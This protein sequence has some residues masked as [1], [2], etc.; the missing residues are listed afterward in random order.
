MLLHTSGDVFAAGNPGGVSAADQ[1]PNHATPDVR[2]TRRA[3]WWWAGTMAALAIAVTAAFLRYYEP[4]VGFTY[5]LDFGQMAGLREM[6]ELEATP[7]YVHVGLPGYDGQFYAQLA[8]RPA[9][10][11]PALLKAIDNPPYRARRMMMGWT[12]WLA[13]GGRPF[14]VLNAFAL[15]NL[16]AWL[17]LGALLLRWFPPAGLHDF[18]RWAGVMLSAGMLASLRHALTDGPALLALAGAVALVESRQRWPAIGAIAAAG[19]TRETSLLGAAVFAPTNWRARREW[20]RALGAVALVVL[21][22]ALWLLHLR[23]LWR[24]SVAEGSGFANLTAPFAGY[25]ERW[26]EIFRRGQ[27]YGWS[28][29]SVGNFLLH[30]SLTVQAL[31]IAT[32]PRWSS[33]WWRIAIGYVG[34]LALLNTAVWEGS[35]GASP[36]VLLPLALAF[37]VLVPR[38]RAGLV[39]LL[40]G[41]LGFVAGLL[42]LRAPPSPTWQ[43]RGP[44]ELVGAAATNDA[45][46]VQYVAGFFGPEGIGQHGWRWT[47]GEAVWRITNPRAVALA[48]R[49]QLGLRSAV[50]Q[51]VQLRA[52]EVEL[53]AGP[54]GPDLKTLEL[55]PLV[56][57]PGGLEVQVRP[58]ASGEP[59]GDDRRPLA[60][61]VYD[62]RVEILSAAV[63]P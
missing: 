30:A 50:F 63:P 12:A 41:N 18:L 57:P 9:A 2:S 54:V 43:V 24:G 59:S 58:S 52:G 4:G 5:V 20:W 51:R 14:A 16:G 39:L 28:S 23:G 44:A 48:A 53:W 56:I 49:V 15:I 6:P 61:A 21:P 22:L 8:L 37:N 17:A 55:P 10:S 27:S 29:S 32:R 60:V 26:Q 34:L 3:R 46:E 62:I 1:D 47:S 38:T 11:D 13:G 33:A 7:H 45:I 35:P 36:R 42:E 25:V 40:A 19:L 31:W